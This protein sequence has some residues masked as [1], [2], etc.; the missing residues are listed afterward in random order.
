MTQQEFQHKY[1][2]LA[3]QFYR[4][5]LALL[6]NAQDAEDAVQD[7]YLKLWN[8]SGRL[9]KME[10]PEAFMHTVLRNVCLNMLRNRHITENELDIADKLPEEGDSIGRIEQQGTLRLLLNSLSPKARCIVTLRHLGDY[11]FKEMA[12][13]T[14]ESESNIRMILSRARRFLREQYRALTK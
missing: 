13:L 1:L 10:Q 9:E 11:S 7:T 4:R 2:P 12:T 5:A 6:G 3:P 14:G 8:Q